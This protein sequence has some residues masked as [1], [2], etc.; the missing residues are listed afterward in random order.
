MS[1]L[2]KSSAFIRFP[3]KVSYRSTSKMYL[4]TGIVGLPNVGKSTLFNA[5]TGGESAQAANF[6]FCTIE[7][8]TG[9]V[10]VKDPRL[11]AMRDIYDSNK[12]IPST[13]EFVDIA[14][15]IQGASKGEGLG[16]KFLSN[17]RACDAI[18]HVVRCF[19][20]EDIIHVDSNI[21]P[22]RDAGIVNLELVL[23]D[24][25]QVE[26]RLTR[27]TKDKKGNAVELGALTR[28]S[29]AL[30]DGLS[31]RIVELTDEEHKL[32]KGLELL[33]KKPVIYAANVKDT[34]LAQGNEMVE[35]I[36]EFAQTEGASV[37]V[38]SAQVESELS[39]LEDEDRT[40]FLS[41]LGIMDQKSVGFSAL[42][43]A[44]YNSLGLGTF[45]TAGPQEI[46]AWTMRRGIKAPQAAGIIHTD[47]E[48]GFIRAEVMG[49]DALI[50][51]G[52]EKA[53]KDKGLMRLEG[54]DY[55]VE[56]GDIVHFRFN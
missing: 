55:I 27:L 18:V 25:E 21:D 45:F 34:D 16:N 9:I 13:L 22:V 7:P 47:F 37:V 26:R 36:K 29:T 33:S 40:E 28:L 52:T 20:D 51:E 53:V 6:P 48:K 30:N 50:A 54:K 38:V 4:N 24:L 2:L 56:E 11:N 44:A 12:I 35:A 31:A 39:S 10:E 41:E 3:S 32:V 5:L 17:I 15:I 43:T 14:G 49:Y 8:N 19:K 1:C 42:V 46:H 23:S